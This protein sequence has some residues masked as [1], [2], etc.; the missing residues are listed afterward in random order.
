MMYHHSTATYF[1]SL[2]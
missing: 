2:V 1:I